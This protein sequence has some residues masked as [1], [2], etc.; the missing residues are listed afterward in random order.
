ME[1]AGREVEEHDVGKKHLLPTPRSPCL[2]HRFDLTEQGET[3]R[4]METR[5]LSGDT[6][7]AAEMLLNEALFFSLEGAEVDAVEDGAPPIAGA[8]H[9]VSKGMKDAEPAEAGQAAVHGDG[10]GLSGVL[11]SSATPPQRV[12]IAKVL[13]WALLPVAPRLRK[14]W[15]RRVQPRA[16]YQH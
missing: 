3:R 12:S 4:R 7:A 2:Q 8:K 16:M 11:A 9:A 13:S 6:D 5:R 1:T 14:T 15:R 10:G